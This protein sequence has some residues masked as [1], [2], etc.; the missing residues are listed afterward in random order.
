M[1][2]YARGRKCFSGGGGILSQSG[3]RELNKVYQ[4]KLGRKG[5]RGGGVFTP[6]VA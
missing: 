4:R 2:H 3:E 1:L 6:G 5:A